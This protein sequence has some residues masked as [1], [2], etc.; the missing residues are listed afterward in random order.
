MIELDQMSRIGFG[1]YRVSKE[2]LSHYKALRES[3]NRGVNVID[4]ATNYTYGDSER[5]IG[6]LIS[7]SQSSESLFIITKA[8]YSNE[9]DKKTLGD[10]IKS[11]KGKFFYS[12]H[13][14]YLKQRI[15]LS[16][17]RLN[18]KRLDGFLLHNPEYLM[19]VVGPEDD[20]IDIVNEIGVNNNCKLI[21]FPYNLFESEAYHNGII[22][23]AKNAGMHILSNRPFNSRN[24]GI[25]IRLSKYVRF[26]NPNDI[27]KYLEDFFSLLNE[28]LIKV[29]DE[30]IQ[31]F[32]VVKL[33]NSEWA[34]LAFP[35]LVEAVFQNKLIPFVNALYDGLVPEKVEVQLNQLKIHLRNYS[36]YNG[37]K[38]TADTMVEKKII[39][40]REDFHSNSMIIEQYLKEGIDTVLVGMRKPEYVK[41]LISLLK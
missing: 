17:S 4:T 19:N 16:K 7:E 20:L 36:L 23:Q 1:A 2:N 15:E 24:N 35:D 39:S 41:N 33:L 37:S 11:I 14:D 3:V 9:H 38:I 22:S 21:Q 10:K 12:I 34:N 18:K 27:H 31:S 28:Q 8:G 30:D 5:L 40:N 26:V 6:N 13:P 29:S 32:E 25:P